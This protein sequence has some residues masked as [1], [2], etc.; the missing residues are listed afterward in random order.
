MP[1]ADVSRARVVGLENERFHASA[2][3]E[4]LRREFAAALAR[5]HG[6]TSLAEDAPRSGG[7]DPLAI[8]GGGE[9]GAFGAGLLTAWENRPRFDLVTGGLDRRAHGVPPAVCGTPS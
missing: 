6:R 7:Y 9:D 3:T 2:L 5:R 1:V 8:S 4:G